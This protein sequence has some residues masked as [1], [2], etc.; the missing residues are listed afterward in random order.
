MW[1]LFS[2]RTARRS[3]IAGLVCSSTSILK[4]RITRLAEVHPCRL[5]SKM[6]GLFAAVGP[7]LS[8]RE[9]SDVLASLRHR[10]PD[11]SGVYLDNSASVTIAHTRLAIID[12]ATGNQP[13]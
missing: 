2:A 8:E 3:A 1:I 9:I 6:C 5:T 4:E 12:L 11:G 7:T 10:G 13:I